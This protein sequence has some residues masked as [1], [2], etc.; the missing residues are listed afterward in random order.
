MA[1]KKETEL[2]YLQVPLPSESKEKTTT[3]VNWSGLNKTQILDTGELSFEENI[4]TFE[5]PYLTPSPKRMKVR[6]VSGTPVGLFGFD[7]FL[8]VLYKSG[9]TVKIDHITHIDGNATVKTG[10]LD[11]GNSSTEQRCVVMMS[12]FEGNPL[13]GEYTKKLLIFPDK[14]SMDFRPS[15]SSFDPAEITPMPN[16]KYA[17][18]HLSRLYGVGYGTNS[19]EPD[20]IFVSGFNDYANWNLDTA[21]EYN[22]SN[23]WVSAAQSNVKA[24]GAFTGITTYLNSVVAFKQDYMHE[25]TGSNNPFRIN[26]IY[27]EGATDNRT[28]QEVDG[29][30]IFVSSDAVKVYT[31]GNPRIISYKL[32]VRQFYDAVAGTDGRRYYLYCADEKEIKHLFVY[33]TMVLQWSEETISEAVL[34]FAGNSDGFYMLTEEG[35]LYRIDSD[36]YN[37][38]NWAAETD[39]TAGKTIDIKH[40]Q[41]VQIL[42]DIAPGSTI[43]AY[44][45]CDDETFSPS[46][47]PIYT[48]QNTTDIQKTATIRVV[49]RKTAHWGAKLRLSGTGYCRIY[50][51]EI[52]L[53][54]GGELYV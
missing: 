42:A 38:Q 30:L 1:K 10:T 11:S 29:N 51:A 12:L 26:D 24:T 52:T 35:N 45:L 5:A 20:R 23:A 14:M 37:N 36:E 48:C 44:L 19:S 49:P 18:V 27:A 15:G 9:S 3:R 7:D 31:G 22:Q 41:K 16:I 40:I 8:I 13:D 47:E 46:I 6:T 2:T 50:Q 17:T 54:G 39:L 28:I 4:S 33:D 43:N 32:G 53:K 25:V 21:T 34:A